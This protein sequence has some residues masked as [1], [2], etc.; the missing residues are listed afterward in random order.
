MN[1]KILISAIII[2]GLCSGTAFAEEPPYKSA[3]NTIL[4]YHFDGKNGTIPVDSSSYK[5]NAEKGA[6]LSGDKGVFGSAIKYSNT[7]NI[8]RLSGVEKIQSGGQIEFW[9][10]PDEKT[11]NRWGKDQR[12]IASNQGGSHAGDFSIGFRMNPVAN[13]GGCFFLI[14]ED[15]DGSFRKLCTPG[16]IKEPR[17][18]HVV[19]IWDTKSNPVIIIDDQVQE[20]K[21]TGPNQTFLGAPGGKTLQIG[22]DNG[23][24][25]A[26]VLL[27][28]LRITA[29]EATQK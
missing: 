8:I 26:S 1:S 22:I 15:G 11:I 9:V 3:P 21:D 25:D 24:K 5:N 12:I 10:K 27:D 16:I 17:W 20:L 23:P 4:L 13:G 18:Y 6:K 14:Q 29:P 19:V 7:S 2:A 28:E